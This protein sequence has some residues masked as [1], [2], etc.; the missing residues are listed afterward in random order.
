MHN[1]DTV[2][3]TLCSKFPPI[4]H[5]KWSISWLNNSS[6][7]SHAY[8]FS[9]SMATK[10]S[11]PCHY[12]YLCVVSVKQL[13]NT[14]QMQT[15]GLNLTPTGVFTF[16]FHGYHTVSAT[17]HGKH[18]TV[19]YIGIPQSSLLPCLNL[20]LILQALCKDCVVMICYFR[21]CG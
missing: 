1:C 11:S 13:N 8:Q 10:D 3:R 4:M 21:V 15:E 9:I 18:D 19:T 16:C 6:F 2:L 7:H 12:R 17:V 14:V 5:T 20:F